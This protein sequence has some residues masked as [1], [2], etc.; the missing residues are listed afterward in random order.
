ML[1]KYFTY[2]TVPIINIGT[3]TYAQLPSLLFLENFFKPLLLI[4]TFIYTLIK[5]YLLIL[6]HIKSRTVVNNKPH[7]I[8]DD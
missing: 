8:E 6:N 7:I 5:I 2:F 1:K 4:A 3:Y